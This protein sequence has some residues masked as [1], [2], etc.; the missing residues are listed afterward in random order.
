MQFYY[1]YV[2]ELEHGK[3]YVG[4]SKNVKARLRQHQNGDGADWTSI[5]K[6]IRIIYQENTQLVNKKEAEHIE[7]VTTLQ[8]MLMKGKDNVRGGDYCAVVL[9]TNDWLLGELAGICTSLGGI[10]QPNLAKSLAE[11]L[12]EGT[13]VQLEKNEIIEQQIA[14]RNSKKNGAWCNVAYCAYNHGK[15][16]DFGLSPWDKNLWE[17]HFVARQYP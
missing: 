14:K 2:L 15:K 4:I 10:I 1:V 5:H 12:Y 17:K 16:C 8:W 7:N 11:K 3:Y 13:E 9:S 6:P